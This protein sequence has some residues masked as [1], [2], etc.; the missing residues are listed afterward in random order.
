MRCRR[1]QLLAADL[2]KAR[3]HLW[4]IECRVQNSAGLSASATDE[5]CAYAGG[6]IACHATPALGCLVV[7]MGMNREQA[8]RT[9]ARIT[10][11]AEYLGLRG[12]GKVVAGHRRLVLF[13]IGSRQCNLAYGP[14]FRR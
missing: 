9:R 5:H 12:I 14:A 13:R 6:G 7:R 10:I 2:C 4:A 8:T 3:L 1:N 11:D